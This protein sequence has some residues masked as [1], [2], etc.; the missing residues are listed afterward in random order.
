MW[1][2]QTGTR[3]WELDGVFTSAC[4][5][6]EGRL[7]IT[8]SKD[9]NNTI[10]IWDLKSRPTR[11]ATQFFPGAGVT[12]V[13][14][15]P[16]GRYSIIA[17][18]SP[19]VVV[20]DAESL[21]AVRQIELDTSTATDGVTAR[22]GG[23]RGAGGAR[24]ARGAG[25]NGGNEG[26]CVCV[27]QVE[28][29]R[30]C[31]RIATACTDG[32]VY[33]W[34]GETGE[35]LCVMSRHQGP[36][37]CLAVSGDSEL[38]MS[39]GEDTK[40]AFWSIRTG[41]K[42]REFDNHTSAVVAVRFAQQQ[43][44]GAHH[45]MITA[46]RNGTVCVRDFKTASI[47]SNKSTHRGDLLSLC[48]SPDTRFFLTTSSDKTAHVLGLPN[49]E[50]IAVL[51]GHREAVTCGSVFPDSKHCLTGSL[52]H[53]LKVWSLQEEPGSCSCV[54]VASMYTDAPLLSCA[55]NRKA[56]IVYG[57]SIGWVSS[58]CYN[59]EGKNP[60]I[61]RLTKAAVEGTASD[62]H[63]SGLD[64]VSAQGS[65]I[66]S[67]ASSASGSTTPNEI[68]AGD[69][70]S[71][72]RYPLLPA[73]RE[74]IR[75]RGVDVD[76]SCSEEQV[77]HSSDTHQNDAAAVSSSGMLV[78][79]TASGVSCGSDAEPSVERDKEERDLPLTR[80]G[81]NK[82]LDGSRKG[83][84]RSEG[85]TKEPLSSKENLEESTKHPYEESAG[86]PATSN[87]RDNN[88]HTSSTSSTCTI[89]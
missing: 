52:D 78:H 15:S 72:S 50:I 70:V 39:G 62:S 69:S 40:V 59:K 80:E 4:M 34:N 13:A 82:Q 86:Q 41:K 5:A 27:R 37:N 66:T 3:L 57:T 44:S 53:T 46:E 16:C 11:Q 17:G 25:G 7:A 60:L 20:C 9:T 21:E 56:L 19:K 38:L 32:V 71:T 22:P 26:A 2:L 48:I 42:L 30:D 76:G 47:L 74:E 23:T 88:K 18:S 77:H 73:E 36:V 49:G 63:P 31:C 8:G 64:S 6:D 81:I 29:M 87:D 55:V 79:R 68:P 14:H 85:E 61:A 24:G 12:S 58:A 89:L 43:S 84:D 51:S 28:V 65:S 33:L 45:V 1:D 83:K 10:R 54:C 75:E 67:H 35:R